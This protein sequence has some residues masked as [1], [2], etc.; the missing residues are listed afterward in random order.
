[1]AAG[2]GGTEGETGRRGE[3][4]EFTK[5]CSNCLSVSRGTKIKE[6]RIKRELARGE[7]SNFWG[8]SGS[9]GG[10]K[11]TIKRLQTQTEGAFLLFRTVHIQQLSGRQIRAVPQQKAIHAA[12]RIPLNPSCDVFAQWTAACLFSCA[13]SAPGVGSQQASPT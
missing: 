11:V 3:G 5:R 12:A 2:R 7:T 10:R 13:A 9:E 8:G 4:A 1:M 6:E